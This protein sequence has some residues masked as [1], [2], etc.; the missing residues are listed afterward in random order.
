MGPPLA[1]SA[2]GASIELMSLMMIGWLR[3]WGLEGV[4]EDAILAEFVG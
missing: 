4:I 3:R 2:A 1:S